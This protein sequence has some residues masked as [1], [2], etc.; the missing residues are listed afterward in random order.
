MRK[1]NCREREWH[2]QKQGKVKWPGVLR[3]V[4]WAELRS[5]EREWWGGSQKGILSWGPVLSG[6]EWQ[7]RS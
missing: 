7:A 3:D 2:R 4:L 1:G 6:L 5:Y